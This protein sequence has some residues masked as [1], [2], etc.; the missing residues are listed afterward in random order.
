MASSILDLLNSL[1]L[2]DANQGS[3]I[4]PSQSAPTS[5]GDAP[6]ILAKLGQTVS[7]AASVPASAAQ[8]AVYSSG[9]TPGQ[10]V[11]TGAPMGFGSADATPPQGSVQP[12][13]TQSA[14]PTVATPQAPAAQNAQLTQQQ[15]PDNSVATVQ[16]G[17]P[18]P[19]MTN[20]GTAP[21]PADQSQATQGIIGQ[22]A[23]QASQDPSASKGILS[24]LGSYATDIGTKLTHLSPAQSQALLAAG[25]QI[26]ASNNGTK[27]LGQLIGE[28]TAAGVNNYN[29][30]QINQA[31]I[32]KAQSQAQLD[33]ANAQAN[34]LNAR[35]NANAPH[36][37]EPGS[38]VVTPNSLASGQGPVIAGG[39]KPVGAPLETQDATGNIIQQQMGYTNGNWGP[40]GPPTLKTQVDT[41]PLA[42]DQRTVVNATADTAQQSA[43]LMNHIQNFMTKLSPT[44]V[45]PASGQQVPNPNY[46]PIP[47]G[48]SATVQQ[49]FASLTGSPAAGQVERQ[50][51]DQTIQQ[52]QLQTYK[53][54]VGGRLTNAD[55]AMLQK[56]L[57]PD[58]AS[59]QYLGQWLGSYSKLLE[60]KAT[61]DQA[62]ASF[63]SQ[64]RGDKSPLRAPLQFNGN[65]YPTGTTYQQVVSHPYGLQPQGA[66]QGQPSQGQGSQ[67]AA[68]SPTA[69]VQAA[70]AA[71]RGGD[72]SAQAALKKYGVQY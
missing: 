34:L 57:P 71:A 37:I 32:V 48:A 58:N 66:G 8:N 60:D 15:V 40:I 65:T 20:G 69:T 5:Y 68:T 11:G 35:T 31:N 49:A 52:A 55:I 27:N 42:A 10:S 7:N 54:G 30:A 28:G 29:Q 33:Q 13:P 53:A 36:A 41:G 4:P 70:I 38:S 21:A 56:G 62:A 47:G 1:G 9:A 63:V 59:A 51:I 43:M 19:D 22:L 18:A 46:T 44:M 23:A 14:Q 50:Q 39:T 17:T 6:G 2:G 16:G 12:D 25:S 61:Q 3:A 67:P 24:Q 45:D 72:V 26:L 64:N